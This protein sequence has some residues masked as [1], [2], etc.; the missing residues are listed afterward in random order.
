MIDFVFFKPPELPELPD[1]F[2]DWVP[3][4]GEK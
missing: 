3:E 2:D 1:G 4:E